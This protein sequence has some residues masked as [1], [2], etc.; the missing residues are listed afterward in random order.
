[1]DPSTIPGQSNLFGTL[2]T[3]WPPERVANLYGYRG[4]QVRK[5]SWTEYEI[6]CEFAELVIH[7]SSAEPD[8]TLIHGA[9]AD[10][11]ANL[12]EIFKPL[13]NACISY[14]L[15]CYDD[16]WNLIHHARG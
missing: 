15:E 9:V 8:R 14:S 4:W 3:T 2:D 7:R 6:I 16:N 5:C 1:M 12:A 13:A 10:V 11:V